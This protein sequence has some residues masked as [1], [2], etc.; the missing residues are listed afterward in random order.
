MEALM[1][2]RSAVHLSFV[3]FDFNLTVGFH[4]C[5]SVCICG[6]Q[7]QKE[8]RRESRLL[9]LP[10]SENYGITALTSGE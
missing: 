8:P 10:C 9:L 7:K 5:L 6:P 2:S 3:K 1:V 4:L